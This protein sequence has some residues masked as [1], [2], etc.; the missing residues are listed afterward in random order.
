MVDEGSDDV[1]I[2]EVHPHRDARI[3]ALPVPVRDV[4]GV[5]N[6]WIVYR[7]SIDGHYLE[8]NLVNVEDVIFHGAILDYPIFDGAGVHDDIWGL[9]H[10]VGCG[11]HALLSDEEGRRAVW[12]CGVL[13]LL[14]EV[15]IALGNGR[16]LGQR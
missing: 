7:Y 13:K 8:V 15:E 5:A 3:S 16:G 2:T 9:S 12:I 14:G 4:V 11:R 10:G 1:G 6:R